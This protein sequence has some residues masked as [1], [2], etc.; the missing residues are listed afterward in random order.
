MKKI[1]LT[2]KYSVEKKA[3]YANQRVCSKSSENDDLI[4]KII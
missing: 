1:D 2:Y 4:T 3:G